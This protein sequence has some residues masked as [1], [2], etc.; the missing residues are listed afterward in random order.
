MS[1][2]RAKSFAVLAVIVFSAVPAMAQTATARVEGI[3]TDNTGAVLPG[4][5]VTATN[6]GTNAQ[7]ID[8]SN[9]KGA[10]TL[11]ALP[12]GP[13][14]VQIDLSGFKPQT[15][16]LTLTVNQVARIDFK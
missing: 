16:N 6:T 11:T 10:Y 15:T 13:Y 8:V 12:V 9:E 3:V 2:F 4:A 5:T 1:S 14:R 7:R